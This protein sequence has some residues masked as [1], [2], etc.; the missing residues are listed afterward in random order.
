MTSISFARS[1]PLILSV[2]LLFVAGCGGSD[3]PPL[4]EASGVLTLDGQPVAEATVSV[5]PVEGGRPASAITD[6]EGR[7]VLKSYADADGAA[8]GEYKVAVIKI[9]GPGADALNG[10]APPETTDGGDEDD[11][12]DGLSTLGGTDG[13]S[14]KLEIIYH[15]PE[16]YG[17]AQNSGLTLTV[18]EEGSDSLNLD[19]TS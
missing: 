17:D 15:V 18:P 10:E 12:S 11:G 13:S 1:T 8:V 3:R 16:R 14:A 19:L 9:S 7:F 6:K 5:V 4:A 2:T